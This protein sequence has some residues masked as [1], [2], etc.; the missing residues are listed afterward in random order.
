MLAR[1]AAFEMGVW[2]DDRFGAFTFDGTVKLWTTQSDWI[3]RSVRLRL[4]GDAWA[5]VWLKSARALFD[6]AQAWD[7]R[8][9]GFA[10]DRL[11]KLMN[12]A[13]L[14][15]DA[16][17]LSREQFMGRMTVE[18]IIIDDDGGF[19]FYFDDGDLFWGRGILV[20]GN[21]QDGRGTQTS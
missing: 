14:D 11:L 21:L 13:W 19:E 15:D 7:G 17:P 12:E 4:P 16:Q 8:V 10:A 1:W 6:D 3:S 18:A 9:R 5:P 2:N 20:N